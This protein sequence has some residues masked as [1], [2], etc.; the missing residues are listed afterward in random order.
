M[1]TV[2][3]QSRW[4]C[5]LFV[6]HQARQILIGPGIKV[7]FRFHDVLRIESA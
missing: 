7:F 6:V 4:R 1:W 5:S 3:S 2:V